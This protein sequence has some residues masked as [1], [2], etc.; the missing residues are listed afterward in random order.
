F[1]N[2]N[3]NDPKFV[4]NMTGV[5]IWT[6]AVKITGFDDLQNIL[7]YPENKNIYFENREAIYFDGAVKHLTASFNWNDGNY[8]QWQK[9]VGD[10][11]DS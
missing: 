3:Y 6:D 2:T 11:F 5:K 1:K 4:D 8:I 9:Q 10:F 7:I